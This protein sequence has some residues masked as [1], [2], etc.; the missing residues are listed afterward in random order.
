[1]EDTTKQE[2]KKSCYCTAVIGVAVIVLAWWQPSWGALA[3]TVL[4][5]IL[6]IKDI[7]GKCGCAMFCK[8]KTDK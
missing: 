4:G 3:L 7:K 6:I 5:A 1:M 8:P 2:A